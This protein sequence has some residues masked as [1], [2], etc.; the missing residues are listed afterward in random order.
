MRVHVRNTM[1]KLLLHL[2]LLMLLMVTL[3]Q[4]KQ[5]T[6]QQGSTQSYPAHYS[7]L[8]GLNRMNRF[9]LSANTTLF[10]ITWR[11]SKPSPFSL[12]K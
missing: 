1:L 9:I 10:K 3:R 7:S 4:A 2:L 5:K 6:P 12:Y 8:A 11:I